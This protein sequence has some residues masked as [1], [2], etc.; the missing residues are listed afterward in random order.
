MFRYRLSDSEDNKDISSRII[1]GVKLRRH[2]W[3]CSDE[4]LD[5]KS[6][7][8]LVEEQEAASLKE[9]DEID[10]RAAAPAAPIEPPKKELGER[11]T[12]R[13]KLL[14]RGFTSL[15][16]AMRTTPALKTLLEFDMTIPRRSR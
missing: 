2:A 13:K 5:F 16:L 7:S 1:E 3:L 11:A 6:M 9:F 12:L 4:K 10:A 8:G 14:A 15:E